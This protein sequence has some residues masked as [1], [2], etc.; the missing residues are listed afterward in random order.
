MQSLSPPDL[1]A[2]ALLHGN[3]AGPVKVFFLCQLAQYSKLCQLG[4]YSMNWS[5]FLVLVC[6]FLLV[7]AS[8]VRD[9]QTRSP[10]RKFQ[11]CPRG[12]SFLASLVRTPVGSILFASPSLRP[13]S[14]LHFSVIQQ[15]Q[16]CLSNKVWIPVL[17]ES[18]PLQI[19]SFCGSSA[20]ILDKLLPLSAV[21]VFFKILC[22]F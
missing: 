19:C 8:C 15:S 10:L 13:L 12:G 1:L 20:W 5:L 22:T 9:T 2:F 7:P 11:R 4:H 14:E 3:A 6:S 18:G 16:Q 21:S 17:L